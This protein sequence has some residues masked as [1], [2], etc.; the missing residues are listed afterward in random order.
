MTCELVVFQPHAGVGVPVVSGDVG[1][2]LEM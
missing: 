1:R 2:S